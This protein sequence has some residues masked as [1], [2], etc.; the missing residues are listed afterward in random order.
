MGIAK[1]DAAPPKRLI[2]LPCRESD[3]KG[4]GCL[5]DAGRLGLSGAIAIAPVGISP[6]LSITTGVDF[7]LLE[8]RNED[9]G[10]LCDV[11]VIA[12]EVVSW[13]SFRG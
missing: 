5:S 9:D 4:V 12:S 3:D 1:C 8:E 7:A 6:P 13:L 10:R 2:P 11:S